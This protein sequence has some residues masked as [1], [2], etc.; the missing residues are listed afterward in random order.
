MD[1]YLLPLKL[2]EFV[3]FNRYHNMCLPL[4]SIER[5]RCELKAR[6]MAKKICKVNNCLC[7]TLLNDIFCSIISKAPSHTRE[8]TVLFKTKTVFIM[9]PSVASHAV[10]RCW[11]LCRYLGL[12]QRKGNLTNSKRPINSKSVTTLK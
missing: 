8:T 6:F 12:K 2:I 10:T 1:I 7:D 9:P 11:F 4:Q 5:F 3:I